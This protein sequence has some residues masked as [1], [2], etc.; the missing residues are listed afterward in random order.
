MIWILVIVLFVIGIYFAVRYVMLKHAMQDIEKQLYEI[1]RDITQNQILHLPLPNQTMETLTGT[2]NRILEDIRKEHQSN[3]QQEK[4]FQEQLE[5]ISHD[6]RTPLTVIL[7]YLKFM[8][9]DPQASLWNEEQ[10]ESL[11]IIERKAR[12]M[13]VLVNEFYTFS[14]LHAQDYELHMQK[15]DVNR[16]VKEALLEDYQG[17]IDASLQVHMEVMDCGVYVHGDEQGLQRVISNLLQNACRYAQSFFHVK[18]IEDKQVIKVFFT[19]DCEHMEEFDIERMF[20]RF[21]KHDNARSKE[22]TGL[23]L[24]VAKSLVEAMHGSLTAG[25]H[26]EIMNSQTAYVLT[27]TLTLRKFL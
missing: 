16:L 8:R 14:R 22:G 18:I 4:V 24:T 3:L 17:F 13:E 2:M 21:Y 12:M 6:L 15:V 1:Q 11:Q 9:K 20:D 19:N 7:G 10:K 26:Q 5:N 27:L 25:I 23:G